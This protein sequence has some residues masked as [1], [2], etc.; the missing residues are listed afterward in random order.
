MIKHEPRGKKIG[1]MYYASVAADRDEGIPTKLY[2]EGLNSK[3]SPI[4]LEIKLSDDSLHRMDQFACVVSGLRKVFKEAKEQIIRD[5]EYLEE[6]M[7]R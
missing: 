7:D 1:I 3:D 6:W 4:Y 5:I 2:V